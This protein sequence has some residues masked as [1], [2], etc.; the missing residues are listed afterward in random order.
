[1]QKKRYYITTNIHIA[2]WLM[3][4]NK[5]VVTVKW[6]TTNRAEFIFN[7]FENKKELLD[8][9]FQE[10][11]IQQFIASFRE[12]KLRMYAEKKPPKWSK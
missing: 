6:P 11:K 3:M 7:D 2:A 12:A 8:K 10:K 4:N 1:M 5:K 9:F